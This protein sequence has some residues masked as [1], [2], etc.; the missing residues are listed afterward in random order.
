MFLF[1]W[2]VVTSA[3]FFKCLFFESAGV[4]VV[5]KSS[6]VSVELSPCYYIRG[7]MRLVIVESLRYTR[8]IGG[9]RRLV[10]MWWIRVD[11]GISLWLCYLPSL[12]AVAF[13][14]GCSTPHYRSLWKTQRQQEEDKIPTT[15]QV[16]DCLKF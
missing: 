2:L 8:I 11:K 5:S 16:R 7:G 13:R 15:H 9:D 12:A 1:P 6:F 10:V 14:L 3:H 4:S